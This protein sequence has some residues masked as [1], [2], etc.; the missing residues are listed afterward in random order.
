MASSSSSTDTTLATQPRSATSYEVKVGGTT[1]KQ[2]ED[3][4]VQNIVLEDH[5][6]MV[7][8]LTI[9]L[10]GAEGQPKWGFKIGDEVQGKIGQGSILMFKGHVIALEPSYQA[11]GIVSIVVRALDPVHI[12]GRGRKTRFWENVK[13]SDVVSE[14]AKECGLAVD[15]EATEETLPYIL[16]RNETNVAFCKRLAAR[17]NFMLR[18]E[19][20]T[21]LFKRNQYKGQEAKV[22]LGENLRSL[23]MSCNSV[24]QVSQVIVRGWDIK[25][26]KEVVG[27]ASSGDVTSIGGGDL[28]LKTSSSAFGESIAYITDVPVSSQEQ[29]TAI[30]KSELERLARQFVRGTATIQGNDQLR[31]GST[32][33]FSGLSS[34]YDG[35]YYVM[36]SRHVVSNRTGYTT[37]FTFCSNTFGS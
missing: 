25:S 21:V 30:A 18:V 2:T 28:G 17:N 19:E 11:E 37:E 15:V 8:M 5:M 23:R 33:S 7:D 4:G 12:L 36:A 27:V 1:F 16:Q 29:A 9:K 34:P 35:K 13:E 3:L 14:V 31:A 6:D 20:S 32:V 24:D 10:G 22:E 26:K